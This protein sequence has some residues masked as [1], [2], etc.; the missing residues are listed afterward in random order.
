MYVCCRVRAKESRSPRR[1]KDTVESQF[2]SP[3]GFVTQ[4]KAQLSGGKKK[5]NRA[6][7]I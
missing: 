5:Q 2:G 4:R 1:K 3:R 6:D 7:D